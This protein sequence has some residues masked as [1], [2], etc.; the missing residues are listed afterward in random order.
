MKQT[1][2]ER[3]SEALEGVLLPSFNQEVYEFHLGRLVKLHNQARCDS[4][5]LVRKFDSLSSRVVPSVDALRNLRGTKTDFQNALDYELMFPELSLKQEIS[6]FV[7]YRI[8]YLQKN[9]K[10]LN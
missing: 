2:K 9:A 6:R 7:V 1:V 5:N 3:I 4:S 10:R 8:D